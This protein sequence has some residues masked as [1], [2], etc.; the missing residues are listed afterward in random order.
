VKS[1]PTEKDATP[2]QEPREL[3]R[4]IAIIMDGN[5]RWARQHKQKGIGGHRAGAT[6]ARDIIRACGERG[7]KVLTLFAFSSENWERPKKEVSGLMAL[8]V[9][10]LQRDEVRQL[11][12]N[13]VRLSFIGRRDRFSK[14]L[15][16]L[17]DD[18]EKLTAA[19]DGLFVVVAADY[20]GRWDITD[21][22]RKVAAK[23][24][25]GEL[26]VSDISEDLMNQQLSLAEYAPPDLCIRTGGEKR[27]SNFLLWQFAY[28][29]LYFTE[30]YWPDFNADELDKALTDFDSRQRRYGKSAEQV[31]G[32][33][34]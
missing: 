25:S 27:I 14:R 23:V 31:E 1:A 16:K 20:G 22:A 13:N 6:A 7:I 28:T 34:E 18:S 30:L 24:A 8:F 3:P 15:Q 21:A 29:E 5:N 12:E 19:N 4:H 9:D 17:M 33:V 10:M 11:H 2:E 32:G 26:S